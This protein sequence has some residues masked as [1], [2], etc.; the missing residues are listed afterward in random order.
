L[1][2][3][4]LTVSF[5]ATPTGGSAWY[6]GSAFVSNVP[7][8]GTAQASIPWNT[9]GFTGTVP[10]RVALDPFN[11][12]AET[13]E[14]NNQATANITIR[15]RPDLQVT[16]ITLSDGEPLAGETVTVTLTLRNHGQTA[17]AAQTVALYQGNPDAGG[18]LVG[19]HI[20][21]PLS[22]GAETAVAFAWT[23]T[24]PGPYRLFT[25]A[26]RD[27]AVN[28]YDEGNNETWRDVYVGLASPVL[29]DSGGA[30]DVA[31]SPTRGYGYVTPGTTVITYCGPD[32]EQTA[33]NAFGGRVE[34]RFDH[35]LPGH[36]YH[37]DITLFECDGL[38]RQE[39]VLVDGFEV[40]PAVNLGDGRA[41]RISLRLDPA[42]YA[43]RTVTGTIEEVQG[44]DAVVSVVALH[45]ID[46]RYA[47]AGGSNDPPYPSPATDGRRYG[48]LDGIPQTR[49]GTLPYQS[50]RIDLGNPDP[51]DDPDNELRYRFDSLK[52]TARYKLLLTFFN[53]TT[54][55]PTLRV[56][57]DGVPVTAEFT[58]PFNVRLDRTVS[59]PPSAYVED[60]S[61]V[62][63]IVRTNAQVG[64]FVNEIALEEETLSQPTEGCNV[65]I[66]PFV[67]YVYGTAVIAGSPAPTGTLI[68]ALNPRGDVVGCF[69]VQAAG[70]YGFMPIYGEDATA[71][72]PIPGMRNGEMVRFR[73]GGQEA[74]AAPPFVWHDDRDVHQVALAV[75]AMQQQVISLRYGWNLFSFRLQPSSTAVRDVLQNINGKYDRI[76]GED[77]AFDPSLPN[78]FN[79]LR[80]LY[81]GKAYWIRITDLQGVTLITTGTPLHPST[82]LP[83]KRGWNWG[84][85]FPQ[86]TLPITVALQSIAGSFDRVLDGR[87]AYVPGLPDEH[88]SLRDMRPGQG[89]FIRMTQDA[90]LVYPAGALHAQ[91]AEPSHL[92]TFACPSAQLTPYLTLAYGQVSVNGE[93]APAGTVVE[94]VTPRGEVAGC[95]RIHTPGSFG[96]MSL[97]GRDADGRT[98]GFLP[99]EPIAW[100]VNGQEAVAEPEL[101][102][103]DE[104]EVQQVRLAAGPAAMPYRLQFPRILR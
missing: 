28:E 58:V 52:R 26:D 11:R 36:F 4:P 59:I 12:V 17:T 82:P 71:T 13:N 56:T 9:L 32:A 100:R 29:L 57:V 16:G 87:D 96:L 75:G 88:Q 84:G 77:G 97:Y 27:N 68:Q 51:S 33:R 95:F 86:V 30:S 91:T 98:P 40:A 38:G 50:R 46:Y 7:A 37:V 10:V 89:Y 48:W 45:D 80:N 8:G 79:S 103:K 2:G 35:L 18:T 55:D 5:Y 85:Y 15:T 64:G 20:G 41:H 61:I 60:G 65:R 25:R 14:A 31:Y 54:P 3:G 72:P 70:Y 99:G 6:I 90:T 1:A 39:R 102:W 74:T 34:Y 101:V 76:I 69:V 63:G 53:R 67:S 22:G 24:A 73:I 43:D 62:V 19:E 78:E 42:L 21:S 49:W 47:D 104:R 44:N 23:P 66:T 94:A 93:P 92:P 83:L 81:P